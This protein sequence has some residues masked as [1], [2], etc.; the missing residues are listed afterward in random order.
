MDRM[1]T[2]DPLGSERFLATSPSEIRMYEWNPRVRY[3][4]SVFIPTGDAHRSLA[5]CRRT[6]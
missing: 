6:K 4:A 1:V 3:V 5:R 2:W